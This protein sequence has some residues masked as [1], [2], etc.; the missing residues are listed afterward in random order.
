MP[1]WPVWTSASSLFWYIPGSCGLSILEMVVQP[2][3]NSPLLHYIITC[4]FSW[5]FY[6]KQLT[7]LLQS[8]SVDAATGSNSALS[9]LLKDT[10]TRVG[11][12]PPAPWLKDGPATSWPIAAPLLQCQ[13]VSQQLTV[14]HVIVSF[15]WGQLI[16]EDGTWVD[17]V[18]LGGALRE[19]PSYP[20]IGGVDLDD[21]LEWGWECASFAL[22]R[23]WLAAI[24]CTLRTC[25]LQWPWIEQE[26]L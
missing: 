7:I 14:A 9:V 16:G 13:F 11:I 6:P 21:E 22:S 15:C 18:V 10:W 5:R 25:L 17:L 3:P 26:W 12:E 24:W 1:T 23:R 20:H 4:H 2:P 19:N 8:Y